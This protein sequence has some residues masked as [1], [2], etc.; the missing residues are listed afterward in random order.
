[1]IIGEY[2]DEN[3]LFDNIVLCSPD[4][5][6]YLGNCLSE[7]N[8]SITENLTTANIS[9]PCEKDINNYSDNEIKIKLSA[10]SNI[11]KQ[12]LYSKISIEPLYLMIFEFTTSKQLYPLIDYTFLVET[13]LSFVF[14]KDCIIDE[15]AY[16]RKGQKIDSISGKTKDY[17]IYHHIYYKHDEFLNKE[18]NDKDE[19]YPKKFLNEYFSQMLYNWIILLSN[20]EYIRYFMLSYFKTKYLDQ[21][22]VAQVNLIEALHKHY[23][24]TKKEKPEVGEAV[25]RIIPQIVNDDDQKLVKELL[26]ARTGFGLRKKTF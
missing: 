24:G 8:F 5:N 16:F 13:F 23:Y 21:K 3:S 26:E 18:Y 22:I 1:M 25:K 12:N 14:Q 15:A 10:I 20:I 7:A 11:E 2:L 17:P 4:L 9:L 19:L 6:K